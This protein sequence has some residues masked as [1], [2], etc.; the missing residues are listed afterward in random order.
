LF[1]NIEPRWKKM[2]GMEKEEKREELSKKLKL[3][4]AGFMDHEGNVK[5]FTE[6]NIEELFDALE[7]SD[8]IVGHNLLRFDYLVLSSYSGVDVVENFQEK[9][10]DTMKKLEEV[11]GIWTSL[12]DLG[13]LNLGIKK[14]ED[15]LKIPKMWRE[16]EHDRVIEYLRTDL[17]ITKRI[18]DWGKSRGELK[19]THKEY[20]EIKGIRTAKLH[21]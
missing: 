16:G 4:V 10:F 3:A 14:S 13:Q 17:E 20:G 5:I 2:S 12:D 7:S 15:P 8:L 21:W 9:T 11:T 6:E 18:Y 19:Y 1:E